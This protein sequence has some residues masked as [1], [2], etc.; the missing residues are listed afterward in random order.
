MVKFTIKDSYRHAVSPK[1]RGF[2][3]L[4]RPFT[5]IAPFFCGIFV[6]LMAANFYGFAINFEKMLLISIVL[7]LSQAGAQSINAVFDYDIDK[8]NK[9]YRP[10]PQGI[11]SKNQALFFGSALLVSSV[12]LALAANLLFGLFILGIAFCAVMYSMPPFRLKRILWLNNFIQALPRGFLSV[13]AVW[14]MYGSI[15]DFPPLVFGIMMF[16]FLMGAQTTKDFPDIEGDK[17]FG[18]K[19]LPV[20]YGNK[21]V[22]L[23]M[24]FFV[25]QFLFL[26]LAIYYGLVSI[27]WWYFFGLIPLVGVLLVN[28]KNSSSY[29]ENNYSWVIMYLTLT[30]SFIIGI[31]AVR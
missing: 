6:S 27:K 14:A 25:M 29:I 3:D 15:S 24:P 2:I 31:F 20:V 12:S 4:T 26:F 11:V 9:P 5:L 30:F 21:A 7:L 18:I 10:I 1:V 19:T 13:N 17:K 28:I 22:F 8:I 23:M 16:L